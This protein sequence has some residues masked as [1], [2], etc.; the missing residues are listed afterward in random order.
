[1]LLEGMDL[2]HCSGS[3]ESTGETRPSDL[4]LSKVALEMGLHLT[5]LP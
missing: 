3:G 4:V 1:M 5:L 2:R